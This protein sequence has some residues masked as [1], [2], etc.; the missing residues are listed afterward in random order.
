M[1]DDDYSDEYNTDEE[2]DFDFSPDDGGRGNNGREIVPKVSPP[3][4]WDYEKAN[5]ITQRKNALD[6]GSPTLLD[7]VDGLFL[8]YDIAL[9]EFEEGK[10]EYQLIRYMGKNFE[11]WRHEDFLFFPN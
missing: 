2:F 7:D 10:I 6:N 9:R 11:V 8:T 3:I 4:M 1:S 5:I